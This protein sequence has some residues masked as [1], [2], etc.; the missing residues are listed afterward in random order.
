MRRHC[1]ERYAGSRSYWTSSRSRWKWPWSS[2][3]SSVHQHARH[4]PW[5]LPPGEP[6]EFELGPRRARRHDRG[7]GERGRGAGG[8]GDRRACVAVG[9]QLGGDAAAGGAAIRGG[10][11][12]AR[13]RARRWISNH[14]R[15]RTR[16]AASG[17]PCGSGNLAPSAP[18][19]PPRAVGTVATAYGRSA[20]RRRRWRARAW[21]PSASHCQSCVALP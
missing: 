20:G 12:G 18:I 19:A 16:R 5:W 2:W 6:H 7:D 13:H 9:H 14:T 15:P 8:P 1:A 10:G 11:P 3:S 4:R 21:R 17:S